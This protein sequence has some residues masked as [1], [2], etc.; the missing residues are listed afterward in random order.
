M[1]VFLSWSGE[2]SKHVANHLKEWLQL[3]LQSVKPWA[4][5]EDIGRGEQWFAAINKGIAESTTG[6]ICLTKENKDKPWILFESGALVKGIDKNLLFTLLIDLQAPDLIG[7]PL[8]HFNHTTIERASML[9]LVKGL[10]D[11]LP[12]SREIT[13]LEKSFEKFWPD[14]EI[15]L[16]ETLTKTTGTDLNKTPAKVDKTTQLLETILQGISNLDRSVSN[17]NDRFTQG[18]E[19]SRQIQILNQTSPYEAI[20]GIAQGKASIET[21]ASQRRRVKDTIAKIVEEKQ[22]PLVDLIQYKDEIKL[23]LAKRRLYMSE[24]TL[25]NVLSDMSHI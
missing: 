2:R 19:L 13:L 8:Y 14:F 21:S 20:S 7:S 1:K 15:Q 22:Y 10:N 11:L 17:I 16:K 6:I 9:Q 23:A 3:V 4:S 24:I 18:D 5:T 25:L 12:E